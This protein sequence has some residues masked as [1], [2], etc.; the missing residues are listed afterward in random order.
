MSHNRKS[1][2]LADKSHI[3][4]KSRATDA[5]A[6]LSAGTFLQR[7]VSS[8]QTEPLG[9]LPTDSPTTAQLFGGLGSRHSGAPPLIQAKLTTIAP[10]DDPLETEADLAAEAALSGRA[11]PALRGVGHLSTGHA[12]HVDS[13]AGAAALNLASGSGGGAPLPAPLLQRFERSFGR[14]LGG[15]RVHSGA[16]ARDAGAQISARAFTSGQNIYFGPGQYSPGTP[17]GDRLIAH[18]VAHTIQQAGGSS[19][20]QRDPLPGADELTE[21]Q[22]AAAIE[23]AITDNLGAE[24]IRE[25]QRALSVTET[26]VF[27]ADFAR[28][29]YRQQR[30]WRPT[31]RISNPG[32]ARADVF[33][34]LGLIFTQTITNA[35][36]G[37]D[38]LTTIRTD[39]PNGVTVGV[40]ANLNA[41][42]EG[43]TEIINRAN[44]FGTA[45]NAVSTEGGN[46]VLGRVCPINRNGEIIE[47]VQSIHRGLVAAWRAAEPEATGDPPAFTQVANLAIFSHGMSYGL[48]I[49]A[50]NN[51]SA[52]LHSG[53]TNAPSNIEALVRG[54][55]GAIRP[56][57]NVQ[58][59]ACSTGADSGRSSYEEWT[60]HAEGERH[61]E[62]SFGDQLA[63]GLGTEATVFSHTTAGHTTENYAAR[64][65][66]RQAGAGEGGIHIFEMIYDADFI[67]SELE[68]LF[69]TLSDED[70][71]ARRNSLREQ[72]WSHFK[73]SISDEHHR[74]ARDKR[75]PVP[76][77]REM[78]INLA[79]A[80]TLVR[81]DWTSNWIPSRLS[82]VTAPA[83]RRGR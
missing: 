14:E 27:D 63:E 23:R 2:L 32:Q 35:T 16:A 17:S 71:L 36:V 49:N 18:E 9:S 5:L 60:G 74:A 48:G 81:A 7:R 22:I 10:A 3:D 78:F 1:P 21:T 46:L 8:G 39:F 73:D 82:R 31:G 45:R 56:D 77:G 13:G 66:G 79:N 44:D 59:Y 69:P 42:I 43:R 52:G 65:F 58:L 57:I 68:R 70:R 64:V 19:V 38:A 83:P 47:V 40:Y 33:Q 29:I 37:S 55:S 72:M 11:A 75:Y 54:I 24:A 67:Q 53:R 50:T 62:D 25:L 26:G 15:V 80:R 30:V 34:R 51:Y 12:Q 6:G 4:T 28:A 20:L 41:G 76:I 61:G